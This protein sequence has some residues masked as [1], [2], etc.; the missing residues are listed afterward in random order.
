MIYQAAGDDWR[1]A[2]WML[3]RR[4]PKDYGKD[5]EALQ[6]LEALEEALAAWR[7]NGKP[8]IRLRYVS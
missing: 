7:T 6:R 3:E 4:Y 5:A 2:A 8:P 1:A